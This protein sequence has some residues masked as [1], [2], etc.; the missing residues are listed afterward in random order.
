VRSASLA[1]LAAVA[2]ST[3]STVTVGQ[4][5]IGT[6]RFGE[7]ERATV[8]G[9]TALF[10]PPTQQLPNSGCGARFREVA[11]G[12]LYAEFRSGRFEGFR[13]VLS[14]WPVNRPRQRRTEPASVFPKL[15]TA[16]GV[17]LGDTLGKVRAE[18]GSLR[19]IG[20]DRWE[21][22]DGLVFYDN[23]KHDPVPSSSRIVEIKIGTCGDF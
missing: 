8:A 14:G 3:G 2:L 16:K 21:S 23:A 4:H 15:R 13:Y 10:G 7:T 12:H 6:V 19:P 17:T 20:T 9:L 11:W 22:A 5:G 18:Y 1:A